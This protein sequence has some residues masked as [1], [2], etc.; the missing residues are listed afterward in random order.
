MVPK[1]AGDT[2]MKLDK[3]F[4]VLLFFF[5]AL[6]ASLSSSSLY[7]SSSSSSGSTSS[8][9]STSVDEVYDRVDGVIS[10]LS[11]LM[12]SR[13]AKNLEKFLDEVEPAEQRV[14]LEDLN[15]FQRLANNIKVLNLKIINAEAAWESQKALFD[16]FFGSVAHPD[17]DSDSE[18]FEFNEVIDQFRSN[19]INQIEEYLDEFTLFTDQRKVTVEKL[20]TLV[21]DRKPAFRLFLTD[22][23]RHIRLRIPDLTLSKDLRRLISL[24]TLMAQILEDIEILDRL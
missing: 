9:S 3:H 16:L 14:N 21:Q 5:P 19:H 20:K 23:V 4:L 7:A 15:R 18:E 6:H 11:T 8:S 17:E 2:S 22:L 10:L 13:T 24:Q 12:D 1:V